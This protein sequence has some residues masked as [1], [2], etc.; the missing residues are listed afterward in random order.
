MPRA[1]NVYEPQIVRTSLK[2]FGWSDFISCFCFV[3][4]YVSEHQC[5]KSLFPSKYPNE[6]LPIAKL[7]T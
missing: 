1:Q 5:L 4:M 6:V 3:D 2:V 7:V